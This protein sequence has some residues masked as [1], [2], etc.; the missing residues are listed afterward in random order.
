MTQKQVVKI[1]TYP[2]TQAIY[3]W[4][5]RANDKV[6]SVIRHHGDVN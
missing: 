3:K 5:M 4:P 2:F 1:F 6:L